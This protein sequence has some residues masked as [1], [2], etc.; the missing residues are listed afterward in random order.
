[1][2]TSIITAV[3]NRS[4][5]TH[6][7][8]THHW[9]LFSKRPE[10]EIVMVNNGSTDDTMIYLDYWQEQF[11]PFRMQVVNLAEN[12]GFGPG[13]NRG[14]EAATG[15][16]LIFISNDVTPQGDYVSPIQA[17][18]Q[19]G[20]IIG[21]EM[22]SHDTGWNRF[23]HVLGGDPIV[24][25]YLAGWCL[26]MTRPTW[27]FMA[28]RTVRLS[29]HAEAEKEAYPPENEGLFDERF[30]LCDYEDLDV[31]CRAINMGITLKALDLPLRHAFGQTAQQLDRLA[32]T[33]ENRRR[34]MEKWELVEV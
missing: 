27:N 34:F 31:A 16:L 4:D 9:R 1:M 14:A 8:L 26:A 25:S 28:V 3:W 6:Q 11:T 12:T 13:N 32:V 20:M 2:K 15:D 21:A 29:A 7:F 33:M 23:R 18:I 30:L 5:L 17:A 24:L 19:D 22:F 10:V